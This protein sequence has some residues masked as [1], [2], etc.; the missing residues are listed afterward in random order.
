ML[1]NRL[2]IPTHRMLKMIMP[3]VPTLETSETTTTS[4][5]HKDEEDDDDEETISYIQRID[6][7]E[8]LWILPAFLRM[9][10]D[11]ESFKNNKYHV[12]KRRSSSKYML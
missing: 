9:K 5:C 4:T 6:F 2:S 3:H 7:D 11:E 1:Y 10:Q 12:R 8:Y